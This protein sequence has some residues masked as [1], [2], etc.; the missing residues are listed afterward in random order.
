MR[1][2]SG[3]LERDPLKSAGKPEDALSAYLALHILRRHART[4]NPAVAVRGE[5]AQHKH[6][7][8]GLGDANQKL[9][10]E[11]KAALQVGQPLASHGT[12]RRLNLQQQA[13]TL[14]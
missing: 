6:G 12:N 13:A 2:N 11:V 10:E 7:Q 4:D 9:L 14:N 5:T 8:A 3:R 1:A